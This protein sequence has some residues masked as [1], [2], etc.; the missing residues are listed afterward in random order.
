MLHLREGFVDADAVAA[1]LRLL[2]TTSPS[3]L[4][5]ASLDLARRRMSLQGGD[6]MEK[7]LDL[8][9][10][11]RDRLAAIA[12]L[13][14]LTEDCLPEN[15]ALDS[16]KLVISVRGLGLAGYQVNG[17]LAGRYNVFVEMA[18]FGNIVAFIS[19]GSTAEDS[20]LVRRCRTLPPGI[21]GLPAAAARG[22]V[23]I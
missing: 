22:A 10:G 4:L 7:A 17:L 14:V 20:Q 1:S 2:Q 3:Y 15:C 21:N 16:T 9:C 6:I 13:R 5:M 8:A 23:H 11:V 12:N 18:D 19:T